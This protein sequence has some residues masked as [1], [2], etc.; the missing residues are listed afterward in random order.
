MNTPQAQPKIVQE[1]PSTVGPCFG[2]LDEHDYVFV[3]IGSE[4]YPRSTLRLIIGELHN[5]FYKNNPTAEHDLLEAKAVSSRFIYELGLK[6]NKPEGISK[7]AEA[8]HKLREVQLQMQESLKKT[9]GTH[10]E[11]RVSLL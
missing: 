6:Y 9:M 11:M 2:L 7:T 10:E 5:E 1:V 8:Q 3:A 4:N